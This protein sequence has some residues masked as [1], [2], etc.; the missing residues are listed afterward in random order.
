D[1][2]ER[3]PDLIEERFR[4][5]RRK[6]EQ[7]LQAAASGQGQG[8]E[9]FF[10]EIM[11]ATSTNITWPSKLK[12]GAKSKKDPHIKVAGKQ[13]NVSKAKEMVM[14]V[15]DT[16]CT[17]VTLKMDVSHNE[18][19]HV[20]GKGGNNI[21]RVM[22]ETGCHIHFPDSNRTSSAEKS[23]QVSIAG[24][25]MGVESARSMIRD[26]LPIVISFDLSMTGA[27]PDPN[28][29]PIQHIVLTHNIS[30]QFKQRA[31]VYCTTCTIRGSNDNVT[32]LLE[33]SKKLMQHLTGSILA[34][35]VPVS[36]QIEVAPQQHAYMLGKDASNVKHIMHRTGAQ[37]RF[38]DPNSLP[39][40]STIY[41]N[42]AVEAVLMAR[43]RLMGCLPL[44]LMFD[45]KQEGQEAVKNCHLMETLDVFISIK[46]KPKQPSKSV[47]VKSVERNI[48]NMFEARRQL[49]DLPTSGLKTS[50]APASPQPISMQPPNAAT[51]AAIHAQQQQHLILQA[52]LNAQQQ[53]LTAAVIASGNPSRGSSIAGSPPLLARQDGSDLQGPNIP[54][55]VAQQ[56]S[57]VLFLLHDRQPNRGN[58]RIEPPRHYDEN[59]GLIDESWAETDGAPM[60][61]YH[62]YESEPGNISSNVRGLQRHI[63]TVQHQMG[64]NFIGSQNSP[65]GSDR[66]TPISGKPEVPVTSDNSGKQ[67][68]LSVYRS[69]S[70]SASSAEL[71]TSLRGMHRSPTRGQYLHPD[72]AMYDQPVD[73]SSLYEGVKNAYI[74]CKILSYILLCQLL[75]ASNFTSNKKLT[76]LDYESR[77]QV[78]YKAMQHRPVATEIRKP[79][80]TWS[81]LGFSLSMPN[82]QLK[83]EKEKY[84]LN[85]TTTYESAEMN[86]LAM[87]QDL[88]NSSK[89]SSALSSWRE[90]NNRNL[91]HSLHSKVGN[92]ANSMPKRKQH[93]TCQLFVELQRWFEILAALSVLSDTHLGGQSNCIE[94]HDLLRHL[95]L[96]KYSEVFTKQ[97]VDLQTFLTLT[98][99]DLTE[100]GIT[101]FGPKK[102]I[103]MA[104]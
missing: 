82:N 38:P 78:A 31:K 77:R 35:Y 62:P 1:E 18:H 89:G 51:V 94:L 40:K 15:L 11:E 52:Q 84:K 44:V 48:H 29:P 26:L 92:L 37:I 73:S 10:N 71:Q 36:S 91:S 17:R 8:G 103:L 27:I 46:L 96:E 70:S 100:L 7:M 97:E 83:Q 104:I 5:D 47:I 14:K 45:M 39:K 33:G 64:R 56:V 101:I 60:N 20:I 72:R 42:G 86:H 66:D 23:N 79:T 34:T 54:I 80:D 61:K 63:L 85:L 59:E 99:S 21:K 98:E 41:V 58:P 9:D 22:E 88:A 76:E 49:L 75:S 4:V 3:D 57:L 25:P 28:S 95:N 53:Q 16:K 93:S 43:Q 65:P 32:G 12:I 67:N 74:R 19:S 2:E 30:V 69:P 13:E 24:Q 87:S 6:L 55:S 50:P 90:R 102:K 68:L 81:G